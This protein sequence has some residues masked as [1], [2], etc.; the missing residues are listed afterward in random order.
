[1]FILSRHSFS[2]FFLV[3]LSFRSS[4]FLFILWINCLIQPTK[5][6]Q[7]IHL[8]GGDFEFREKIIQK[9]A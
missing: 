1:M 7:S 2:S 5:R 6:L 4:F 9:L 8:Q 3:I